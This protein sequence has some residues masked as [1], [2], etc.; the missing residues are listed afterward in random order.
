MEG[1]RL[2]RS[3]RLKNLLSFGSK[4]E[5][6]ELEPLNV[7]IGRNASGKS[8]FIEAIRLLRAIPENI[9]SVIRAG[10]GIEAWLWKGG[11]PGPI[12]EMEAIIETRQENK[13]LQHSIHFAEVSQKYQITQEEINELVSAPRT[14]SFS[15]YTIY[16]YEYGLA[17]IRKSGGVFPRRRKPNTGVGLLEDPLPRL[18]ERELD[19]ELKGKLTTQSIL[20]LLRDP[21][22]YPEITY[23]ALTFD[24]AKIRIYS[25]W[26]V[27]QN[28]A[29]RNPQKADLP[30]D[31]LWED[32]SNLGLV[33][34]HLERKRTK[35]K[36]IEKL[37]DFYREA[38]DYFVNIEGGTVQ[39]FI[40]EEGLSQPIPATRLSDGTLRYLCL[41]TILCHPSPPP[42]ICIEEPELGL[43]PDVLP[44]IAELLIEASQRT[45]LIVTTHSDILVSALS[46]VPDS[47]VVCERDPD[48]TH[49]RRLE[50]ERLKEWLDKY[51]LGELWMMGEIE[52]K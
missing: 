4:G 6:I 52:S 18:K 48:G 43:H 7:L 34:N 30:N 29:L 46:G 5:E 32:A 41:L 23:L 26:D 16:N 42:L 33:L 39:V 28:S 3:I 14:N 37:K 49:M 13:L 1:K 51:T 17:V 19:L 44:T 12:A 2:I 38:E 11:N 20:S 9:E 10:G 45:Q 15:P 40:H 47:V 36:I 25:P 35:K 8:N 21:Q 50:R 24:K 22:H 31:F 27:G